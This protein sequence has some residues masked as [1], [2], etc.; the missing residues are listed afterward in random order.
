[1]P[2]RM[3]KRRLYSKRRKGRPRMRW[4]DDVESDLKKMKVKVWKE[5]MGNR[6]LWRLVAEEAK[7]TQ[8]CSAGEEEEEE[9]GAFEHGNEH[10]DT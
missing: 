3:L 4:L 5:K 9:E 2:K 10:P 7:V 6:V 1:M 8:G